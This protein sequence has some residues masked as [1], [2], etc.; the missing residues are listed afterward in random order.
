MCIEPLN[1][2]T[3]TPLSGSGRRWNLLRNP[4]KEMASKQLIVHLEDKIEPEAKFWRCLFFR[5]RHQ[6]QEA[7]VTPVTATAVTRADT[8]TPSQMESPPG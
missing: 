1:L 6:S 8:V 5:D 3:C 2:L 7:T 4:G